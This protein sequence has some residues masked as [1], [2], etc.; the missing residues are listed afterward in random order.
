MVWRLRYLLAA[1]ISDKPRWVRRAEARREF[2]QQH[3]ALKKHARKSADEIDAA[4][5]KLEEEALRLVPSVNDPGVF[6]SGE[7][8]ADAEGPGSPKRPSRQ[9]S[10]VIS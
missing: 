9:V 5:Q 7:A 10:D 1:K 8:A 4:A 3:R 6:A 2:A